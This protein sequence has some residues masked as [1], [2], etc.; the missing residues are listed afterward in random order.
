MSL[1]SKG[2]LETVAFAVHLSTLFV[3]FGYIQGCALCAD[4]C[5]KLMFYIFA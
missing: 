2:A 1:C 5:M 4:R 3:T